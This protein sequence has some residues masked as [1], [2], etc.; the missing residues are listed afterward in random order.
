MKF[1]FVGVIFMDKYNTSIIN[2]HKYYYDAPIFDVIYN[3]GEL[4]MEY[5]VSDFLNG[6]N[7]NL[8]VL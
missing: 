6:P 7:Y 4:N 5:I 3:C 1:L 8:T 2:T